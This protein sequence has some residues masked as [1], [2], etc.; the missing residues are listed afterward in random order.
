MDLLAVESHDNHMTVAISMNSLYHTRHI[1]ML[2]DD[3]QLCYIILHH[4]TS[5]F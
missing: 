2:H 5:Q 1:Y 4:V 3:A